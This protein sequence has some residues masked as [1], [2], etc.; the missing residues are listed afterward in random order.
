MKIKTEYKIGIIGLISILVL[1]F[2][3]LF[4]KGQDLFNV[5]TSYYA[6]FD[7]VSGLY[8]S[9]YIYLNG[10]KVGYIKD[11]KNVDPLASKFL[12]WIAVDSEIKIPK[13]SKI[14]IFSLDLLGSKALKINMGISNE[15]FRRKDTIES[16]K[17][18]GMI[19]QLADN[20]TPIVVK[21]NSVMTNLDTLIVGVNN[22]LD[23][24]AQDDV[25][26][27]LDNIKQLTQNIENIT[28]EVDGLLD[29]E[30]ARIS[31]IIANAESITENFKQN[32]ES[33]TNAIN[34][35]SNISDTIA[36]ANLGKTI[37]EANESL[38][39]LTKTMRSI[40]KGEGSAGLLIN[41][42]KLYKNLESSTK[43]LDALIEDIKQNPKRY[44]K[45]SVF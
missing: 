12:V 41:D 4:L 5:E 21:L 3:I 20:I 28:I 16:A 36:K 22:I 6:V 31:T 11:I 30:K 44:L 27:S 40:E 29:K 32:N 45:F 17:E 43:K 14:M 38:T 9:N 2:G 8:K 34:N 37:T 24:K 13:D 25:K 10:M 7:D 42:D 26:A 23:K 33:L 39:S 1:Y 19:D 18:N 35:F 15:T